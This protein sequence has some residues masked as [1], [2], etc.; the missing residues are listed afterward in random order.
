MTSP[1]FQYDLSR[2][3]KEK[4]RV[5]SA[6]LLAALLL[7]SFKIAVGYWTN[8][9]GILSE[10]AH[11]GLD[12]V[13]AAITL[14]AVRISGLPADREHTYGHGKFENL[15]ALVE[16]FLLLV[17]C[18]W[19]IYEAVKRLFFREIHVD[20]NVWAFVVVFVSIIIDISRS[21]ALK[22][23]ADKYASQALEADALHFATD[24]WSSMVV[25]LGLMGVWAGERFSL[26]WLVK[27]DA[28][29]ALGV[30]AIVVWVSLQLGKK[31]VADLLDSVPKGMQEQVEAAVRQV[32][33]VAEVRQVRL[34]RS[35]P[36]F[37]ADVTLAVVRAAAFEQTHDIANAAEAAIR[38][39]LPKADVVVHVEPAIPSDEDVTT[40]VR[41]LAARHGLGA[42]GIRIYEENRQRWLELHLEVNDSLLLEE[43]HRQASEFEQALRE[44]VP[45][46]QRIV[47]HLEP[48]GDYAATVRSQSAGELLIHKFLVRFQHETKT[49][50]HPHDVIVQQTGPELSVS[51]H[52]TLEPATPIV[53]AHDFTVRL[54]QYLRANIPKLGRVVIHVEPK[55]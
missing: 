10:G 28:L 36:E 7:T 46:L 5:A 27:A 9:L 2:A 31:T 41:L 30:A 49:R 50:F 43:A 34:R 26:P 24:V 38:S 51:L 14:W 18:F 3:D 20:L 47:T 37:F 21:R 29:A 23:A 22:R 40:K 16:T 32:P 1:P 45:S 8:S 19:I 35:G 54:E 13:A 11:S 17:T 4:R 42:H 33:G 6:S 39:I 55:E 52:C 44:A 48:A 53:D 12:M 25:L 15:S